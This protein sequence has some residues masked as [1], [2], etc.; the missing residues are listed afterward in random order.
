MKLY[1][2]K[3]TKELI[4]KIY[5]SEN[6]IKYDFIIS[7]NSN[8]DLIKI[9]YKGADSLYIQNGVLFVKTSLVDIIENK[10]IAYQFINN[11]NVS[12]NCN[13]ILNDDIVQFEFPE[14][15]DK[16]YELVIDP[17]IVFSTY[18]NSTSDN[19]AFTATYD[20]S[21]NTYV[22]GIVFGS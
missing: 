22:G 17:L 7:P 15:Y 1:I 10:P 3:F 14:G 4:F 2:L 18:S 5:N 11:K 13:Y 12:V 6:N 21:G 20:T 8:P 19:K 16:N 9:K